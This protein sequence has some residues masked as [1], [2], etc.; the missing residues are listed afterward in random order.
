MVVSANEQDDRVS[1]EV[2][3]LEVWMSLWYTYESMGSLDDLLYKEAVLPQR[4]DNLVL[5]LLSAQLLL[6]KV[7]SLTVLITASGFVINSHQG[8]DHFDYIIGVYPYNISCIT[9]A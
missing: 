3:S 9:S 7:L 8:V 4:K 6:S 1:Y 2:V 5:G